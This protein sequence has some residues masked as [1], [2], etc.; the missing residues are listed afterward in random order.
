MKKMVE[1]F[2][3]HE[4]DWSSIEV[5]G[6]LLIINSSTISSTLDTDSYV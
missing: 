2:G 4:N 3:R 5:K 6:S 1:K